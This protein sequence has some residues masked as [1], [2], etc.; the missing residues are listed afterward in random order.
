MD[1]FFCY[2][3]CI[4]DFKLIDLFSVPVRVSVL[5]LLRDVSFSFSQ[6]DM[7]MESLRFL[8][9]VSKVDVGIE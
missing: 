4:N 3:Y 8:I 5:H 6:L 7:I 9:L 2:E 1:T